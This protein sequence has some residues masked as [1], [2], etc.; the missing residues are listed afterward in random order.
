MACVVMWFF[1]LNHFYS[2]LTFQ[3]STRFNQKEPVTACHWR[4]GG[5]KDLETPQR[6][7]VTSCNDCVMFSV[8]T[9]KCVFINNVLEYI[10]GWVIGKLSA[11]IACADCLSALVEPADSIHTTD[12]LLEIKNNPGLLRPSRGVQLIIHRVLRS[13]VN[14]T[15]HDWWGHDNYF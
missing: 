4:N 10:S 2:D 8:I 11:K 13:Q 3:I 14:I 5:Y 6:F 1:R 9:R 15:K 12:S 7:F